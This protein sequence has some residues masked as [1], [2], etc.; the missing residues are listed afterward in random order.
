MGQLL[1]GLQCEKGDRLDQLCGVAINMR[2]DG[3]FF[4]VNE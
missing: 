4:F 3:L 2:I 1:D